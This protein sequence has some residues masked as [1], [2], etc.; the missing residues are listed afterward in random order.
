ME[1]E[2]M[3]EKCKYGNCK[4]PTDYM[5][6]CPFA[7]EINDNYEEQCTCCDDCTYECAMDI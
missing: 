1:N 2:K 6:S 4:N 5:H 7:E 3:S